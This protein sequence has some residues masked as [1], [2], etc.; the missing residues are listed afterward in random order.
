M[1]GGSDAPRGG[2]AGGATGGQGGTGARGGA[3]GG[4]SNGSGGGGIGGGGGHA[5]ISGGAGNGGAGT[6]G[7]GGNAGSSGGAGKGGAGAGGGGGNA[8]APGTGGAGGNAPVCAFST[9]YKFSD[10]GGFV[11]VAKHATLS[12]PN[13][14]LYEVTSFYADAGTISCSP[15]LPACGTPSKVDVAD[16]EA[17]IA[18]PDVQAAL[19]RTPS[20]V[21][22]SLGV[23]DGPSF[24]F[25]LPGGQGFSVGIACATP[26]ATCNPTPAGV[27]ALVQ[28]LR[29]LTTQQLA[30][31]SCAQER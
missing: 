8:G 23:A 18:N 27:A 7:G 31:P 12:P 30:D 14:F 17:A 15:A 29:D 9:T 25:G 28:V 19:I 3:G 2:A 22:G 26:S 20:P 21:Y 6:G 16:V 11:P 4:G 13:T 10:G 5:G 24:G 1:D